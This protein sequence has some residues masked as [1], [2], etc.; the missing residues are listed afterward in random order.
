MLAGMA[1]KRPVWTKAMR[2]QAAAAGRKG[3]RAGKA[4]G[5]KVGGML[6]WYGKTPDEQAAI[7]GR[8]RANRRP[9]ANTSPKARRAQAARA[10]AQGKARKS[11]TA[12]QAAF[13]ADIGV[14]RRAPATIHDLTPAGRPRPEQYSTSE[15][16]CV[17]VNKWDSNAWYAATHVDDVADE[18]D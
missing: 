15:E 8:L 9:Q 14:L 16:W 4:R 1:R 13:L 12:K 10:R 11:M 7:L 5:G 2:R 6:A 18:E 17:A 3:S